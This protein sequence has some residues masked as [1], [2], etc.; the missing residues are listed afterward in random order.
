MKYVNSIIKEYMLLIVH[1]VI[2][3]KNIQ[4]LGTELYKVKN[5]LLASRLDF[6]L[7]III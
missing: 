4:T 2:N 6:Y 7:I 3:H 1:I 5:N